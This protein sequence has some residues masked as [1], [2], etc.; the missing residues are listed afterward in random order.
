MRY[1]LHYCCTAIDLT[2]VIP[3]LN[4]LK[5]CPTSLDIL[6]TTGSEITLGWLRLP[7]PWKQAGNAVAGATQL[8]SSVGQSTG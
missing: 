2:H 7:V 6:I 8:L 5:I 4:T 1:Y 3:V